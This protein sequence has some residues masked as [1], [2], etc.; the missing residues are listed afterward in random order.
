MPRRKSTVVGRELGEA[1]RNAIGP[2]KLNQRRLAKELDWDEAKLS[3]LVRGKGGVNEAEL[4]LLLGYCRVDPPEVRRLIAL[5]HETRDNCYLQIPEDGIPDQVRTLIEQEQLANA[6]TVWSALLVP[7]LLQTVDY[8]RALVAEWPP[9]ESVDYEDVIKARIE[10]RRLLHWDRTF[11][12]YIHEFALRLPVGGPSVMKD[13]LIHLLGVAE[14]S[15]VTVKVV[16]TAIGPHAGA[17]GSF[18]QLRYEKFDPVIFIESKTSCL[19]I[20]D[21]TSLATYARVLKR[22]DAQALDAE[23]S[24]ELIRSIQ[25]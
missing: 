6:I 18:L 24:K 10:R 5:F 15:Y 21:P 4:M 25:F 22:L 20:E 17:S 14:R 11:V 13:Q 12:F 7:G 9:N 19:F 8:M 1:V 3:D 16:P 23:D 2:T